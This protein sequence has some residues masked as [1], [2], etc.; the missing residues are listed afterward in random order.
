MAAKSACR[1][2][3]D[4]CVTAEQGVARQVGAGETPL[5]VGQLGGDGVEGFVHDDPCQGAGELAFGGGTQH[6]AELD[7]DR[8]GDRRQENEEDSLRRRLA[9]NG[10]S[11][12]E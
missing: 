1:P 8:V 7:T 6:P 2:G 11:W 12:D 10:S 4:L 9:E 5:C 3:V